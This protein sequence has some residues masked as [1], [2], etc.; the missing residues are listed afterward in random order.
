MDRNCYGRFVQLFLVLVLLLLNPTRGE[1]IDDSGAA[2]IQ[3][4]FLKLGIITSQETPP[5]EGTVLDMQGKKI[6]LS[7]FRGK[8]AFLTF[9]T[10]W[11]PSCKLEMPVL[12]KLYARYRDGGFLVLAVNI[13]EPPNKVAEYFRAKGLSY[14]PLLD[15]RGQLARRLGVRAVPTTLIV[16]RRGLILGRAVGARHWDSPKGHRLLQLLLTQK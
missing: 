14:T 6:E 8:V 2:E 16:N 7:S 5:L 4:L 13:E 12:E 1:A 10:T 9:W 11:C 3:R 15:P